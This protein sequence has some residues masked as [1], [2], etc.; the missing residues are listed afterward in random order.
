MVT[1]WVRR[2]PCHSEQVVVVRNSPKKAA[3]RVESE[4]EGEVGVSDAGFGCEA[5]AVLG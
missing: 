3:S 5:V 2:G 4:P 1:T